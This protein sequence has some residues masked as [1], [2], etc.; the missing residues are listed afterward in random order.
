MKDNHFLDF[1]KH[2][3]KHVKCSKE[4]PALLILD[5][6]VS[7]LSIAGL[8]L[9]KENGLSVLTF[10]PHCSHKLQM[11]DVSVFGPFKKYVNTA[12]DSW[13]T[14]NPG[15]TM[16]IY[17][18]PGIVKHALPLAC[19]PNNITSGFRK[20]GIYPFNRNIFDATDSM[21]GYATDRIVTENIPDN[22]STEENE[23]QQSDE[24]IVEVHKNDDIIMDENTSP[25]ILLVKTQITSQQQSTVQSLSP[26]PSCSKQIINEI[27]PILEQIR[28]LPKAGPRKTTIEDKEKLLF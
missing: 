15:K 6:H 12:C 9:A 28:P 13:M 7:H 2:F 4:S 8:D 11:L 3:I 21:P 22:N 5:N 24:K 27:S 18:I 14:N 16:N 17:D 20:T 19:T 23:Q 25:N 1:L 10:P 26:Q